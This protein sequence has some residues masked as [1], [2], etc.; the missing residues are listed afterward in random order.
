MR[1]AELI[2][3]SVDHA[4]EPAHLFDRQLPAQWRDRAPKMVKNRRGDE[5]WM[6]EGQVVPNV[7]LNASALES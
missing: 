7:G 6:F 1:P 3:L 4:V 5:I 2:L